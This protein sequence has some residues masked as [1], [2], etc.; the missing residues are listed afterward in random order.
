MMYAS[1]LIAIMAI[2]VCFVNK[3]R[4]SNV[5]LCLLYTWSINMDWMMHIFGCINWMQRMMI[6]V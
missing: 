3:G 1:K 2:L 6:R 5:T 4:V